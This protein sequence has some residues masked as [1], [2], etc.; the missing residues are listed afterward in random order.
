MVS[1]WFTMVE[2]LKNHHQKKTN[3]RNVSDI[4]FVEDSLTINHQFLLGLNVAIHA[5]RHLWTSKTA[6]SRFIFCRIQ[7]SDIPMGPGLPKTLLGCPVPIFESKGS[8]W[9]R[10]VSPSFFYSQGLLVGG[11][12]THLKNMLVNL[13]HETPG[14]GVNIKHVWNHH[15]V[16]HH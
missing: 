16:Y 5:F 6:G 7:T 11:W 9:W 1:W 12:T 13:D 10:G 15:L 2:S 4:F 14:I 8:G 3:P